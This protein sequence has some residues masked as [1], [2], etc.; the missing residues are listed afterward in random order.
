MSA[1][2]SPVA[3]ILLETTLQRA[4]FEWAKLA[5]AL[6]DRALFAFGALAQL[7]VRLAINDGGLLATAEQGLDCLL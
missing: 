2:L 3:Q 6:D 7:K 5:D 1:L 4:E